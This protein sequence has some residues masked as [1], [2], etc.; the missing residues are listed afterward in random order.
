MKA[1]ALLREVLPRRAS[2]PV[3][4]APG[5]WEEFLCT[6]GW[7]AEPDGDVTTLRERTG[8]TPDERP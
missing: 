8:K 3:P 1:R 2:R 5:D 7:F 4:D 6:C